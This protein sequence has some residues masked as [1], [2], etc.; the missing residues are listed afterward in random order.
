MFEFAEDITLIIHTPNCLLLSL[1][2][3]QLVQVVYL[4][5]ELSAALYILSEVNR[6][7]GSVTESLAAHRVS[8]PEELAY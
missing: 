4:A 2:S 6:A 8:I 7:D 1:K 3:S 5:R